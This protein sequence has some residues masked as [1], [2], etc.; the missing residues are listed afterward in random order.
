[1]DST[2]PQA[3]ANFGRVVLADFSIV[4]L[5]ALAGGVAASIVAGGIVL[6]LA[7]LAG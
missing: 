4:F 7:R 6:A 2:K 5:K 3:T 1:M